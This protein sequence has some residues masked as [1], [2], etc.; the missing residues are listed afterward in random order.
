MRNERVVLHC[1]AFNYLQKP[2]RRGVVGHTLVLEELG[3]RK[4]NDGDLY[5]L[6][7]SN[8]LDEDKK[9]EIACAT[10]GET[11][12]WME[13]LEQAKKQA[14]YELSQSSNTR[15]KLSMEN[16]YVTRSLYPFLCS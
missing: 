12:K 14:E 8:R 9:G 6:K 2:I 11:K 16:E 15:N 7:F 4:V 13:A 5:V 10:A 1:I 3:C